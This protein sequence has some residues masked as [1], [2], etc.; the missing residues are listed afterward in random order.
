MNPNFPMTIVARLGDVTVFQTVAFADTSE[1]TQIAISCQQMRQIGQASYGEGNVGLHVN[2]HA[3]RVLH[4]RIRL[5]AA[6]NQHFNEQQR[7]PIESL[8]WVNQVHG[9]QVY[10]VDTAGLN[11]QPADADALVSQTPNVGLA[12]MTADCVPIVLYQP[13]T[14]QIAAIH[15]GWQGLASGVIK[16][17]M[18][19]FTATGQIIAWIGDCI[20]Q[21]NYEVS[22]QVSNKLLAGCIDAQLL[23]EEH[24]EQFTPLFSK[25]M[26][27]E[28]IDSNIAVSDQGIAKVHIDL[29]KLAHYQ[30]LHLGIEVANEGQ[31]CC[32]Y[33]DERYYSYRRQ[34]HL[35]QPATGR[36]AFIIA[37]SSVI[38]TLC[39]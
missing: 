15:A 2:D 8:N 27:S 30:L 22:Q 9:N 6:I 29:P 31:T 21:E 36:M 17:T 32:S 12:I 26:P 14:G 24:I 23:A 1:A 38:E 16:A 5:L 10:E 39:A 4:N 3:P 7:V 25:V 20:S 33:A 11:M 18:A 19:R 34:T 35:Q 37:R 28:I 13:E